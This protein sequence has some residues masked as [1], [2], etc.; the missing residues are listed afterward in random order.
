[1]ATLPRSG[2][3]TDELVRNTPHAFSH[4]TFDESGGREI[5]VDVQGVGDLFT[6]PQIHTIDGDGYG[7]GNMG[8]R[9]IALFFA[10]HR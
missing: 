9:G 10:S 2:F 4:F 5:V 7:R 8:V 3:V 1:M 6:D